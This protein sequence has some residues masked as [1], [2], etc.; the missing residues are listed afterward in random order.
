LCGIFLDGIT[1]FSMIQAASDAGNATGLVFFFFNSLHL[2]SDGVGAQ[3]LIERKA[4]LTALLSGVATLGCGCPLAR[5]PRKP[6][7]RDQA[8][9]KR[10]RFITLVHAATKSFT[11]FSFESAHA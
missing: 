1:S 8:R 2:G 5:R 10:S 3:P 7:R 6:F 11:N 4:R 9:S